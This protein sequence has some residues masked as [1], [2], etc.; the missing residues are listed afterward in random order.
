MIPKSFCNIL[1][2]TAI[3]FK[4]KKINFVDISAMEMLRLFSNALLELTEIT[5]ETNSS[6]AL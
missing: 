4:K 3:K 5:Y 6:L 1:K 2:S